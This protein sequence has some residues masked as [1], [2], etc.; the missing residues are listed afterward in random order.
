[1]I[2]GEIEI[3][4]IILEIY[5]KINIKS[6]IKLISD[7]IIILDDSNLLYLDLNHIPRDFKIR[8]EYI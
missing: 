4:L 8:E 3:I 1:M 2:E 7:I 5:D 6:Y